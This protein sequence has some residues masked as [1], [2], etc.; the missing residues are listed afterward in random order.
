MKTKIKAFEAKEEPIQAPSELR[1]PR[2]GMQKSFLQKKELILKN[3]F[4]LWLKKSVRGWQRAPCMTPLG[5]WSKGP[6]LCLIHKDVLTKA[7]CCHFKIQAIQI[8]KCFPLD[9]IP[10]IIHTSSFRLQLKCFY[11]LRKTFPD[12]SASPIIILNMKLFLSF[13]A[14]NPRY[15]YIFICLAF[16]FPRL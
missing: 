1:M 13:R 9:H 6:S 11:L 15:N 12:H 8:A 4:L 16:A 2:L 3:L 5:P 10:F 14:L 7:A